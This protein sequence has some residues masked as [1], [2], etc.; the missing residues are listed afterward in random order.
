MKAVVQRVR[1]ATVSIDGN[2]HSSIGQG[3]LVLLGIHK[4]DTDSDIEWMVRKVANMR[5][6]QDENGLMNSDLSTIEGEVL[7]VSQFTLI[8]STKKG[9]RPSFN[10][11]A[12]PQKGNAY[13]LRV[14]KGLESVLDRPVKTGVFAANMQVSLVNDGPVTITLDTRNRE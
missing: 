13:Y 3:F 11:A 8:A 4:E 1:N 9:N 5:V 12:D 10:D 6:F 14:A 2:I 7:V